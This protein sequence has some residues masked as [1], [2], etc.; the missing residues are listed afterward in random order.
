VLA[1]LVSFGGAENLES[2]CNRLN[3]LLA[4][5]A[6]GTNFQHSII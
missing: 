3:S 4:E 1:I 2:H 5:H 6:S